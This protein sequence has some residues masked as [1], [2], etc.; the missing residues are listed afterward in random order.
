MKNAEFQIFS[1]E[2]WYFSTSLQMWL[3]SCIMKGFLQLFNLSFTLFF[4]FCFSV[5]F[6][7][8]WE[9]KLREVILVFWDWLAGLTRRAELK[10]YVFALITRTHPPLHPLLSTCLS[11]CSFVLLSVSFFFRTHLFT[12]KEFSCHHHF[13]WQQHSRHIVLNIVFIFSK[14][15]PFFT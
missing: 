3:C 15:R 4:S 10:K 11:V 8:M 5:F 1:F 6:C 12:Y 14:F 13:V 7:I 2:I 9:E